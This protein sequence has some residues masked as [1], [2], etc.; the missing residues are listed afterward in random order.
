LNSPLDENGNLLVI[1]YED[2]RLNIENTLDG[3][4]QFLGVSAKP[5][6]IRQAIENNNLQ[7]LRA[8]EKQAF[9]AGVSLA[10]QPIRG[11][12][13]YIRKG[14]SGEWRERLTPAQA[15]L[16]EDH[17]G[18]LLATLGYSGPGS[19][20]LAPAGISDKAV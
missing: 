8:K 15:K 19:P 18:E 3:A 17:A 11:G 12:G 4:L 7:R 20:I 16:I 13:H 6:V 14:S 9:A 2:M 5:G 10:G 1:K